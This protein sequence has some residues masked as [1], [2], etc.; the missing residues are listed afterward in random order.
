MEENLDDDDFDSS[1]CDKE[2]VSI[3]D[4]LFPYTEALYPLS[5]P[6][7]SNKEG[8]CRTGGVD[9]EGGERAERI[10]SIRGAERHPSSESESERS[11]MPWKI[12]NS[13][14]TFSILHCL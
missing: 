12:G 11:P 7:S 4:S 9:M 1:V 2:V 14:S 13:G 6:F 8:T 3:L 10:F 5:I